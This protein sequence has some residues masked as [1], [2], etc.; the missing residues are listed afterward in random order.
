VL[1]GISREFSFVQF[2]K[3]K[4]SDEVFSNEKGSS[5]KKRFKRRKPKI[6]PCCTSLSVLI[7]YKKKFLD[8]DCLRE[9]Q[10][11]G[12]TVQKKGNLTHSL[13]EILPKNAFCSYS[14]GFL[15]TVLL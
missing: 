9:M 8:S 13:P 3:I 2:G 4:G 14:S 1:A 10:F 6:Q 11:L 7:T 15:V 5:F 12:N